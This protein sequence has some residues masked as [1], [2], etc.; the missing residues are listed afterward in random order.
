MVTKICVPAMRTLCMAPARCVSTNF[1]AP[2]AL[3][4]DMG[5][6]FWALLQ[7]W[8]LEVKSKNL[9]LENQWL[10]S[11]NFPVFGS[12]R[13]SPTHASSP[14]VLTTAHASSTYVWTRADM[15]TQRRVRAA[16]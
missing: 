14:P 7:S 16:T 2:H 13:Q 15:P 5:T 4:V 10:A 3:D 8:V 11:F 12:L 6:S 9:I 1:P